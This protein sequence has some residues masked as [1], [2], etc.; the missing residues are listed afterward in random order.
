VRWAYTQDT[1]P[2]LLAPSVLA[3]APVWDRR[4]SPPRLVG[5]AGVEYS[6]TAAL[7]AGFGVLPTPR[8]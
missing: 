2:P 7:A 1:R 6:A 4:V 3:V 8:G 5:A